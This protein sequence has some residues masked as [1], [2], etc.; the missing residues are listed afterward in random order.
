MPAPA[1]MAER[2][3]KIAAS[4]PFQTG[5]KDQIMHPVQLTEAT[6]QVRME[7]RLPVSIRNHGP[8]RRQQRLGAA[9]PNPAKL[10]QL[11]R[12]WISPLNPLRGLRPSR[13]PRGGGG[14]RG[15]LGAMS[16]TPI[17]SNLHPTEKK[18][19]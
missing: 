4:R 2:V 7:A 10:C 19:K 8:V 16:I 13:P 1:E 11:D 18:L 6:E 17:P 12:M 15:P 5:N 14:P 9:A 3:N